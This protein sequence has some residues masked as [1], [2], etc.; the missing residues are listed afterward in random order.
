MALEAQWD[1]IL[2]MKAFGATSTYIV[3]QY[4]IGFRAGLCSLAAVA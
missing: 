4:D 2:F 1:V 3:R